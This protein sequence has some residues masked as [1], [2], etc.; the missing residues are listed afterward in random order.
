MAGRLSGRRIL[1][2]E[3]EY[4]IATD[5]KKALV[6]E[7]AIVVGPVGQLDRALALMSRQPVD[8]AVL[9]VN[10]VKA[11]T[12]AIADCLRASD[13]PWVFVTGYDGWSMPPEY[14]DTPRLAKPFTMRTVID[15]VVDLVAGGPAT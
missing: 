8:A 11:T 12:Y 1:V 3:D 4:F 5:I 15:T 14:R 2:V 10:L 6:A 9:D 13:T 7:D